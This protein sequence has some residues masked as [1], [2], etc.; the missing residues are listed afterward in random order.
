MK[1]RWAYVYVHINRLHIRLFVSIINARRL[2]SP[3]SDDTAVI[4][5]GIHVSGPPTSWNWL[6]IHSLTSAFL[7]SRF[8]IRQKNLDSARAGWFVK[9]V[10]EIIASLWLSD[11]FLRVSH[12]FF[13]H[14]RV[15]MF[16]DL[17]IGRKGNDV[18]AGSCR[19]SKMFFAGRFCNSVRTDEWLLYRNLF[20]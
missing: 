6:I 18:R 10:S 4:L 14:R 3:R 2:A 5:S 8:N 7:A 17:L 16:L 1:N 15:G 9:F 11:F 20:L 12:C 19:R 13:S